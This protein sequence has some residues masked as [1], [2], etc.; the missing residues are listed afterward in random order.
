MYIE[1][2]GNAGPTELIN[3][4]RNEL[5]QLKIKG[6]VVA[7]KAE[8][9]SESIAATILQQTEEPDS[10]LGTQPAHILVLG[11]NGMS[12]SLPA[13]DAEAYIDFKRN[14]RS[15]H[16]AGSVASWCLRNA[17]CSVMVVTLDSLLSGAVSAQYNK[18]VWRNKVDQAR[19]SRENA[20]GD[21]TNTSGGMDI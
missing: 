2:A 14:R 5:Q 21:T 16:K 13:R 9:S 12:T 6:W 20:T 18:G 1:T 7:A 3:K 4:Y 15:V 19:A 11:S 8:A 17:H 10:Q